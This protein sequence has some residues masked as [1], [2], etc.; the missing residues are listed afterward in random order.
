MFVSGFSYIPNQKNL[1]DA[2]E[3]P[4]G[5]SFSDAILA[6]IQVE[7]VDEQNEIASRGKKLSNHLKWA[8]RKNNCTKV[9]LHSF[10]H[11][12]ESKASASFSKSVFDDAEARLK[13]V[14][15]EVAQTPFGYFLD[16]DIKA[17]GYSLARIWAEL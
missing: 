13:N 12:G 5:A 16:L 1:P 8:C 17:P 6:M 9:V 7:E 2:A 4:K 3:A 11:L 14:G 15:Y 10:A